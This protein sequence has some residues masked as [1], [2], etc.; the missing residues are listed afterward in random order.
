MAANGGDHPAAAQPIATA[1]SCH[2]LAQRLRGSSPGE[3]DSI[4]LIRLVKKTFSI[5]CYNYVNL[6]LTKSK[7]KDSVT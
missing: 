4:K 6:T 3:D 5:I 1:R 2:R 7:V